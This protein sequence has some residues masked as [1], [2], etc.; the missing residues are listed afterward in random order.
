MGSKRDR[1]RNRTHALES[2]QK[3]QANTIENIKRQGSSIRCV[4]GRLVLRGEVVLLLAEV[5][6]D[7][8][9]VDE[10]EVFFYYKQ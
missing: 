8:A 2:V 3:K 1:I 5:T 4:L 6:P 7:L 10:V 9:F